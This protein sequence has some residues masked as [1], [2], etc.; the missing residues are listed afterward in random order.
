MLFRSDWLR[1]EGTA[2]DLVRALNDLRKATGLEI[3]DRISLTLRAEGPVGAAI[4][5]HGDTIAAEVLATSWS[6]E[7]GAAEPADG[8]HVLDLDDGAAAARITRA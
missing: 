3:A 1:R 5:E 2:R 8:W 4:D 6:L 7:A